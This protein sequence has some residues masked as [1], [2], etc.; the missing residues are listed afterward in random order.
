MASTVLPVIFFFSGFS[1]LV[2]ENLWFYQAGI[3]FGNSVWA[4]SLVLAGFMGGL[5][6]GNALAARLQSGRF[7]A[8]RLYGL[9]ELAIGV[10]G[11]ALVLILP[12]LTSLLASVFGPLLGTPWIANPLR[13]GFAFLLL[14]VPSTAMGATLPV[15][16]SALYRQDP[17]FGA[18][19][20]RLYGWNTLG[21][22][23]GA[24][25][26]DFVLIEALG[27]R[28]TGMAAAT[29]SLFVAGAAFALSKRFESAGEPAAAESRG[30]RVKLTAS[31]RWLLLAAAIAGFTLL[32]LEVAWFRLLVH[33][34]HA[35]SQTF[36]IL[37]ATVL[38]GIGIGGLLGGT[39]ATSVDRARRLLPGVA[40]LTGLVC[41]ALY[42]FFP[43]GPADYSVGNVFARALSLMF[44]VAFLSGVLFTLVGACLKEEMEGETR[45][46][47]LLTL[48]NTTGAM[49]GPLT[50]GFVLLPTLGVDRS[51][52][53]LAA[54]YLVMG[55]VVA[56]G[57]A[58]PEDQGARVVTGAIAV[59]LVGAVLAFPA[60]KTL[61]RHLEPV[62]ARLSA[63]IGAETV[64]MREGVTE[65]IIYT[66][67]KAFDEPVWHRMITN[68]YSMSGTSIEGQRYMKLFVYLPLALSPDIKDALLISYGVGSTAKALT[69]TAS[70][71]SID[72]VD[73]S[74]D[75]LEMNEIVFPGE[76]E[77]PLDD[78]RVEVHI[79]DGRYFM[80]VTDKRFDLITG[81]PPPPKMAGIVTLYTREYFSLV[82][83]RLNDG[84]I[85]SYW[86]PI[87]ALSY[88]DS[89]AIV[90]AFCEVFADCTL[91]NGSA[92][93]WILIGT[94]G[95]T[96]PESAE[97]FVRQWQD[98]VTRRDLEAIGVEI[99]QQLGAL[100]LAGPDGL[101]EL[102]GEAPPLT[103]DRPK[104]LSDEP[105]DLK[106]GFSKYLPWITEDSTRSRFR[107]SP[108]IDQVWPEEYREVTLPYFGA[109]WETS[110]MLIEKPS[111]LQ[112]VLPKVHPILVETQ[113]STL[114]LWLLNSHEL[115]QE[116]AR[117]AMAKGNVDVLVYYELGLGAL[118]QRRYSE[119]HELF[120][121]AF[122][123]APHDRRIEILRMYALFMGSGPERK[124]EIV[125]NT[126]EAAQIGHV[127]PWVAEFFEQAL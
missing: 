126:R 16:V 94:R 115:R 83:D 119:A 28:G 4:S 95:A 125:R 103:D 112:V 96:G 34:M 23:V 33:F 6:L 88:E 37:L 24:L 12:V 102:A 69:N 40:V 39:L 85:V 89:R 97:Q 31:A 92:L 15:M 43:S 51:V 124:Q 13:L 61:E 8:I 48:A 58:L 75:V 105:F 86:L 14:L 47:G 17:R 99:P 56:A 36:A 53:I 26:G 110:R 117:Q 72:V 11:F 111:D 100:F 121:T 9:I 104:R 90:S 87:H 29:I 74:R 49:L 21:A 71:E 109:Q 20:G 10:S 107:E 81:E 22:V 106:E 30:P 82:R 76:G 27:V 62:V 66:E 78:P 113:L 5:A 101:T 60:G 64:A 116:A 7:R 46:A 3:T 122:Q 84:G 123:A 44:P 127:A 32:G 35:S 59:A 25:A 52:Q 1:A 79:E 38:A 98:P 19:L 77:L 42:W 18:V 63:N 93:D 41:I 67:V 2:F 80:E 118:A 91:W 114:P 57:G 70:L 73:T 65:T 55:V 68:G 54:M 50:V 108:W 45:A 120:N